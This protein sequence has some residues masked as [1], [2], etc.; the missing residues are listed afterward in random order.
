VELAAML[1]GAPD[2]EDEPDPIR[3]E[4]A[5]APTCVNVTTFRKLVAAQLKGKDP[6]MDDAKGA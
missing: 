1:G 2:P 3:L 4:Y 6:F 5:G